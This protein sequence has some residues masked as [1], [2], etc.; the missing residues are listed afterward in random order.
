MTPGV[1]LDRIDMK[2]L[3]ELQNN[4]RITNVNLADAVGLRRRFD[5][6]QRH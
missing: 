5:G 3:I 6:P 2:I 4:S 1:R